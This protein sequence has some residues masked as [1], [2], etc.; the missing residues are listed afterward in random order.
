MPV[1]AFSLCGLPPGPLQPPGKPQYIIRA[2]AVMLAELHQIRNG[3]RVVPPSHSGQSEPG[4]IQL[5]P[6]DAGS[7]HS[8]SEYQ[9]CAVSCRLPFLF[10]E[11]YDICAVFVVSDNTSVIGLKRTE[12]SAS[13]ADKITS[14]K[15]CGAEMAASA[16][17]CPKCGA[18]TVL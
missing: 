13:M 15:T 12:R 17:V 14:C 6:A 5:P 3:R 4:G 11:A 9:S 16:E 8:L 18:K 2:D 10:L 1:P 7:H